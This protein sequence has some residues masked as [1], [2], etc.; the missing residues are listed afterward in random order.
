MGAGVVG[1]PGKECKW[2][3]KISGGRADGQGTWEKEMTVTQRCYDFDKTGLAAQQASDR[4]DYAEYD[5]RPIGPPSKRQDCAG[6]TFQKLFGQGPF[7]LEAGNFDDGVIFWFG[8]EIFRPGLHQATWGDAQAGD[9]LVYRKE[10]TA[11]HIAWVREVET[12]LG[13][14]SR[15]LVETKESQQGVFLHPVGFAEWPNDPLVTRLGSFHIYR[16]DTSKVRAELVSKTCDCGTVPPAGSEP[17]RPAA[18]GEGD[19]ATADVP[20]VDDRGPSPPSEEEPW[21]GRW[22]GREKA[23]VT[24]EGVEPQVQ[25]LEVEFRIEDLGGSVK[26]TTAAGDKA[27]ILKKLKSNPN[28]AMEKKEKTEPVP[29]AMAASGIGGETTTRETLV[30]FLREGRLYL[31]Q[32]IDVKGRVVMTIG[33]EKHETFSSSV[34]DSIGIFDRVK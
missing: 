34:A 3:F 1:T 2:T 31:A 12:T 17:P 13:V 16:V 11:M 5:Y 30:L 9:V 20:R 14:V 32:R 10:G 22:K 8:R 28:A 4:Q 25:E 27:S 21:A 29:A 24:M 19:V 18:E 7:W 33:E 26:L 23:T 15:I 6:Y